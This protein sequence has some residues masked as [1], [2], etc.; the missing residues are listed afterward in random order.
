MVPE[1]MAL[2][3]APSAN[4]VCSRGVWVERSVWEADMVPQKA[5]WTTR[6]IT[7]VTGSCAM[8]MSPIATAPP[9]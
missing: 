3:R 7:S 5:P 8:L 4:P 6:R 9:T 2:F 1:N